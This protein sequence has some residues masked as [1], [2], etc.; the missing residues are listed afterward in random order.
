MRWPA[1]ARL[2]PAARGAAKPRKPHRD[3]AEQHRQRMVP[4]I[5]HTADPA[6]ARAFR[7]LNRVVPGLRGDDLPL[8][9]CQQPLRLGQ[10]QTQ[11]GDVAE[12]AGPV[13]L[14]EVRARPFALSPGLHQPQH[15]AHASILGQRTG[16]KLSNLPSHPQ[17]RDSP[18][19]GA[20]ALCFRGLLYPR[21]LKANFRGRTLEA[22]GQS[23]ESRSAGSWR[24]LAGCRRGR[25]AGIRR[26]RWRPGGWAAR[27][28]RPAA[29]RR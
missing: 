12:I 9:T 13:D 5:L 2:D 29:S 28:R 27:P 20:L 25:A 15:P 22:S 4:I 14:Q 23:A 3:L 17:S 6:T 1:N 21:S 10:G 16:A 11:T 7:S 26:S 19:L 18:C 8:N 24:K